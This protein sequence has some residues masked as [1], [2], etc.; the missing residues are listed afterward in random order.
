M[1]LSYMHT[2]FYAPETAASDCR[3]FRKEGIKVCVN[4]LMPDAFVDADKFAD[5]PVVVAPA[6]A[7]VL[8][9]FCV[10]A[11]LR[12]QQTSRDLMRLV[13]EALSY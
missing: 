3:N 11:A 2:Y 6:D 8:L 12:F 10:C 13:Y 9:L 5:A 4:R 7:W 1:Y